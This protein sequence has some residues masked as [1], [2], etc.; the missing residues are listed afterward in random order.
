[1]WDWCGDQGFSDRVS[2]SLINYRLPYLFDEGSAGF[3]VSPER[4]ELLC[5]YPKDAGTMDMTCPV[6][7]ADCVG[8]CKRP[9]GHF[10][11]AMRHWP[12]DLQ[13]MLQAHEL[14]ST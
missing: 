13:G 4:V 3:V 9:G 7:S 2:C 5:A 8:G 1:M 12:T 6:K 14:L 11:D 10:S